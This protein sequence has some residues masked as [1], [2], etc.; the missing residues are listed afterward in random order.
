MGLTKEETAELFLLQV[1]GVLAMAFSQSGVMPTND[2][3]CI[4][5]GVDDPTLRDIGEIAGRTGYRLGFTMTDAPA[6]PEAAH[7]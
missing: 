7:E 6:T 3:W 5:R 1:R 4:L 2:D